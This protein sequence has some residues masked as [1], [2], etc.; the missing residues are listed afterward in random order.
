MN[1]KNMSA[2]PKERQRTLD[3]FF[4]FFDLSRILFNR[5]LKEIYNVSDIPKRSRFYKI[6][7]GVAE[8]LSIDWS[9]MSHEDSNRIMLAMLESSFNKIVEIED[10]SSIDLIVKIKSKNE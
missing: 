3:A 10:S 1:K 6:A 5:R 4:E 7:Q 8:E 2:D 9:T